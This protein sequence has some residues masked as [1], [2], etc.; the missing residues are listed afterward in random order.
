MDP[1]WDKRRE[2]EG[3]R[4]CSSEA[5]ERSSYV[6]TPGQGKPDAMCKDKAVL[7]KNI[8]GQYVGKGCIKTYLDIESVCREGNKVATM[9][10]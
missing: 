6:C 4:Q 3:L 1:S 5:A 7:M 8:L 2:E 9:S 10:S